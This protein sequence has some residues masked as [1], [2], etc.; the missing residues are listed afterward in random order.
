MTDLKDVS[1][2]IKESLSIDKDEFIIEDTE[3]KTLEVN[4]FQ[5]EN[6]KLGKP[7][8]ME[9]K[10][11]IA[12]EV[13]LEEVDK[14][15]K[16]DVDK[17]EEDEKE[18]ST[19]EVKAKLAEDMQIIQA[20][21]SGENILKET[22]QEGNFQPQHEGDANM[23]EQAAALEITEESNE[24][25]AIKLQEGKYIHFIQNISFVSSKKKQYPYLS[26]CLSVHINPI[27]RGRYL[28][29]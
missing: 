21:E 13:E 28:S 27:S 11:E 19:N 14:S 23:L 12:E 25:I 2:E 15:K 18:S 26:I 4:T 17:T 24:G 9:N 16:E 1:D 8:E 5:E 6:E 10:I 29:R 7:E 3:N 20:T 22:S